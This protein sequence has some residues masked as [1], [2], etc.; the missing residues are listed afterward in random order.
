[1]AVTV[2]AHEVTALR[3]LVAQAQREGASR[4]A[5]AG[6]DV[7]S[8]AYNPFA[9]KRVLAGVHASLSTKG[10]IAVSFLEDARGRNQIEHARVTPLG[11]RVLG[12]L[13]T[14]QR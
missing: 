12:A 11:L 13:S 14:S 9:N 6:W 5:L 2:T 7:A 1:M 10:L 3:A 4:D 8:A